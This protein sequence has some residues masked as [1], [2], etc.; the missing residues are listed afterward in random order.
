MNFSFFVV[1]RIAISISLIL[2]ILSQSAG[3]LFVFRIQRHLARMEI[4]HRIKADVPET[5][6]V[7]LKIPKTLQNSSRPEFQWIEEGEFRYHG[8]MYD[9]VRE[10]SHGD[11]TWFYSLSDE[12]ETLLFAGL[13]ELVKQDMAGNQH[14]KQQIDDLLRLLGALYLGQENDGFMIFS[15]VQSVLTCHRIDLDAWIS[16]PATPPPEA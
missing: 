5:E 8:S 2:L 14:Y 13:D 3:C 15:E 16:P 10:V 1:M 4:K 9:V 11:T 7:L 6:L 12:K